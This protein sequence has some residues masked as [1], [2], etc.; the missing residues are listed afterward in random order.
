MDLLFYNVFYNKLASRSLLTYLRPL[1]LRTRVG[2]CLS[3]FKVPVAKFIAKA[4]QLALAHRKLNK[5]EANWLWLLFW[6]VHL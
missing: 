5:N 2:V 4:G 3:G 6:Y 1:Y